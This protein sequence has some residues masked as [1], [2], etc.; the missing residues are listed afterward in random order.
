MKEG[1]L[2]YNSSIDRFDITFKDD[3][4]YGGLNCG[5]CFDVYII[6]EWLSTR[7]EYSHSKQAWYLV[8]I[9]YLE[10]LEYEERIEEQ[11]WV[12]I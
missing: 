5:E 9:D 10:Y 7:I 3:D 12:R 1:H 6:G 11:F 4:I 2:F 8:G